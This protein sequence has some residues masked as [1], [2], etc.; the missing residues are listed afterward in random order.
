MNPDYE[1]RVIFRVILLTFAFLVPA[2]SSC[3]ASPTSDYY[4]TKDE[5]HE[6]IHAITATFSSDGSCD[7]SIDND[8][9]ENYYANYQWRLVDDFSSPLV[10]TT[11]VSEIYFNANFCTSFSEKPVFETNA[12]VSRPAMY[13]GVFLQPQTTSA[14]LSKGLTLDVLP[15]DTEVP[16]DN[17]AGV[18][19]SISAPQSVKQSKLSFNGTAVRSLRGRAELK[20]EPDGTVTLRVIALGYATGR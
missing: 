15:A 13:V 4:L 8:R 18:Y 11:G 16:G 20:S 1:S 19:F 17:P 5:K 6:N 3:S 12:H 9:A 2:L 10:A 14:L 7:F